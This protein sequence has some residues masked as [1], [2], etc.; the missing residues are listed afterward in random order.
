MQKYE[1]YSLRAI[2][3]VRFCKELLKKMSE[4]DIKI[5]DYR[6]VEMYDDY[7]RLAEEGHKKEYAIAV[8][9][10]KY[11]VSES[12]LRRVLKRLAEP[13]KC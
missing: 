9:T 12:T 8:I 6:H 1:K 13:V 7:C 11:G 4:N 10:E 3:I 2:D 5:E